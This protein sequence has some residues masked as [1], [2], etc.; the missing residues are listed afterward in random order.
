MIEKRNWALGVASATDGRIKLAHPMV[1]GSTVQ[2]LDL[3]KLGKSL[4]NVGASQTP[5]RM[6]FISFS[7]LCYYG[8]FLPL[9]LALH[10]DSVS[11]GG[12]TKQRGV[13]HG[14]WC[15]KRFSARSR[16]GRSE[17]FFHAR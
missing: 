9:S 13:Q 7:G 12:L 11:M 16:V 4:A 15:R 3:D 2:S 8:T 10:I 1:T 14:G 6:A 5:C 17:T